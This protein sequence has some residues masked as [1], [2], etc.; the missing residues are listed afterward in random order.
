MIQKGFE[1]GYNL[2]NSPFLENGA[3]V[4]VLMILNPNLAIGKSKV[5]MVFTQGFHHGVNTM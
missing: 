5:L 2:M 4:C 1:L 3:L